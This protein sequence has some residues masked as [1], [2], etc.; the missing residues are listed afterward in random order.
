M[1]RKAKRRALETTISER[2]S[3]A[4]F[5]TEMPP[6]VAHIRIYFS[7]KGLADSEAEAFFSEFHSRRWMT[8]RGTPVRNWKVLASDW[9]FDRRQEKKLRQRQSLFF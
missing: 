9:I 5:G 4:G 3:S 2:V 8:P 6:L 1:R 7:Q